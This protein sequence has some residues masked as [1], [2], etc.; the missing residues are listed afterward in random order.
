MKVVDTICLY[1]GYAIFLGALAVIAVCL[2]G[3]ALVGFAGLIRRSFQTLRF[4]Y[5]FLVWH[6]CREKVEA[7]LTTEEG[8]WMYRR[9]MEDSQSYQEAVCANDKAMDEILGVHL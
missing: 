9:V 6:K 2:W 3:F 1:L 8:R 7:Y 4:Y 5:R